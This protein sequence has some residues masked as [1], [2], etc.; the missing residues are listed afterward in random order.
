MKKFLVLL[1]ILSL[2][3]VSNAWYNTVKGSNGGISI[4]R[5]DS[6]FSN[7]G[8]TGNAT[9]ATVNATTIKT[10]GDIYTGSTWSTWN[11]TITAAAGGTPPQYSSSLAYYKKIGKLVFFKLYLSGDGGNEGSGADALY[12]TLPSAP[13]S[14]IDMLCTAFILNGTTYLTTYGLEVGTNVMKF[15]NMATN[16]TITCGDQSSTSRKIT[17]SGWYNE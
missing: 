13:S 16:A 5:V 4:T 9:F 15:V 8:P 11:V 14:T 3:S 10:T 17:L 6:N 2:G 1:L 7:L 12:I